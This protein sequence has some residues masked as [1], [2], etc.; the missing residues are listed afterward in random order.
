MR[1]IVSVFSVAMFLSL[2][3]LGQAQTSTPGTGID[4]E[5]FNVADG[6]NTFDGEV[7]GTFWA[8]V[9]IRPGGDS[10]TCELACRSP[11]GIAYGGPAN[12]ATGVIDITFDTTSLEYL[13]SENNPNT[14]AVDGLIQEQYLNQ[15]RIGW[16]LAGDWT[17]D[18]DA[19]NG[20]LADPC[21]MAKLSTADW[22]FRVQFKIVKEAPSTIHIRREGDVQKF[23]LSF[24]DVCGSPAFKEGNGGIDEVINGEVNPPPENKSSA[25][26]INS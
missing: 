12:I 25:R 10:L 13:G 17:P 7:D 23:P 21:V 9:F 5:V 3:A 1:T 26:V 22:V 14:A 8:H 16:A 20:K 2:A 15:G 4:V 6:G 24:A 11:S 18:A 19:E